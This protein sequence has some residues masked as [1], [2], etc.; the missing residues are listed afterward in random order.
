MQLFETGRWP[1]IYDKDAL[2]A[3]IR[4]MVGAGPELDARFYALGKLEAPP[5]QGD[6]V[7]LRGPVP[8]I[9]ENGEAVVSN[10][11]FDHWLVIANSCD[12][13]RDDVLYS[14]IV[15]LVRIDT[16]VKDEELATFRRYEF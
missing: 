5:L 4:D 15:P 3:A 11:D 6:I 2:T 12:M 1:S 13:F 9:D 16:E 10:A 8:L 14:Q 7:E